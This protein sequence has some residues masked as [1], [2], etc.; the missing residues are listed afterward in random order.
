MNAKDFPIRPSGTAIPVLR[1]RL[2][3]GKSLLPYLERMDAS[4]IYSNWGPLVEELGARLAGR[5]SVPAQ[6]VV[7]CNS[8]MSA[9]I[10]AVLAAAGPAKPERHL[11]VVPDFTFVATGLA[12]KMCGYQPVLASCHRDSWAFAAEDLLA[13]PNFLKDVG[14]VVPVAPF[15]RPV[16]Q[17][18]WLKFRERTGIPVVIDGAACF[19]ALLS[20]VPRDVAGPLPL[21]LSFHATKSFAVGEGGAVV[22]TDAGLAQK[23]M[24]CV[25]FGFLGSRHSEVQSINGKMSEYAAAVGLAELDGWNLK[26][27]QYQLVF[28]HYQKAWAEFGIARS[29]WGP[30][31]ISSSYV[32]VECHSAA[33]ANVAAGMLSAGGIGTRFWYG[34]GLREHAAFSQS[35]KLDLHPF[36]CL[37]P[38]TLLG[39]P[40]A[41]DL[42]DA[43][44]HRICEAFA[45]AVR[46]GPPAESA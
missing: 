27:G 20:S 13:K 23:V 37:D 43:Q 28:E 33:E 16:A 17:G 34:D 40:V 39:L 12:V 9:L 3:L 11:A 22:T 21:A 36:S 29:L 30:T 32:L 19:E 38:L 35:P 7:C 41:P 14:L 10:G 6:S 45:M 26:I 46:F 44:V 8:G 4:R 42:E 2:P 5:F 18:E 24:Q 1:P 31:R 15:G 25:N